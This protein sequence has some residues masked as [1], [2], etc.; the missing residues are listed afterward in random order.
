M[1]KAEI[2]KQ[3]IAERKSLSKEF[4]EQ[5]SLD[6]FNKAAKLIP[7]GSSVFVYIA[8]EDEVC[9][10]AF[11][12]KYS[13]YSVPKCFG[14]GHMEV[15]TG[16]TAL[17]LTPFGTMEPVNGTEAEKIDVAIVPGIAFSESMDRVGYGAGYYDRFLS[18]HPEIKKIAVCYDFQVRNDFTAESHDVK[19]D[20][21]VTEKRVIKGEHGS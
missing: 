4:K 1:D 6:I 7:R 10:T 17:E 3:I 13:G 5:A 18:A 20:F 14:G 21:I 8:M 9:T 11:M 15:F 16:F 12:E 2:R 19:M